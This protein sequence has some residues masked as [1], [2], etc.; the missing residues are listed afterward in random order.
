MLQSYYYQ[1]GNFSS[2]KGLTNEDLKKWKG[3]TEDPFETEEKIKDLVA[4]SSWV[5]KEVD[6]Y[7]DQQLRQA[8]QDQDFPSII[9]WRQRKVE[10]ELAGKDEAANQK[11]FAEFVAF[12]L[13]KT[14]PRSAEYEIIRETGMDPD[15]WFD[16]A[17]QGN[18]DTYNPEAG[19]N[20]KKYPPIMRQDQGGEEIRQY[21][22]TF[23]DRHF[24]SIRKTINLKI[25]GP[26]SLAEHWIFF[27]YI[28][29]G[30][31]KDHGTRHIP[32]LYLD[33]KDWLDPAAD[34]FHLRDWVR[35]GTG[36]DQNNPSWDGY[37]RWLGSPGHTAQ[38]PT[39]GWNPFINPAA[40]PAPQPGIGTPPAPPP[41]PGWNGGGG[42]GG[43]GSGGG[44]GGGGGPPVTAVTGAHPPPTP[45]PLGATGTPA[46]PATP[47]TDATSTA[48]TRRMPVTGDVADADPVAPIPI[49]EIQKNSV[50]QHLATTG[51]TELA[52]MMLNGSLDDTTVASVITIVNSMNRNKRE[53]DALSLRIPHA[54]PALQKAHTG[55]INVLKYI[56]TQSMQ[57]LNDIRNANTRISEADLFEE[58]NLDE[59][60]REHVEP[61]PEAP[62]PFISPAQT[63][64][65]TTTT[66][67]TV[68]ESVKS[69][70]RTRTPTARYAPI[71][72]PEEAGK[73][74]SKKHQRVGFSTIEWNPETLRLEKEMRTNAI[75]EKIR[76]KPFKEVS[77]EIAQSGSSEEIKILKDY[78]KVKLF[79]EG[80]QTSEEDTFRLSELFLGSDEEINEEHKKMIDNWIL[81]DNEI[82]A[83]ERMRNTAPLLFAK[84]SKADKAVAATAITPIPGD[85]DSQ[86]I[87]RNFL[88]YRNVGDKEKAEVRNR[89]KEVFAD[90]YAEQVQLNKEIGDG[91]GNPKG[92]FENFANL[93]VEGSET[94]KNLLEIFNEALVASELRKDQARIQRELTE[95]Q[96]KATE[97]E[98][99]R[100]QG[101]KT[102]DELMLQLATDFADFKAATT[103]KDDKGR[104]QTKI[105]S[106]DHVNRIISDAYYATLRFS[107]Q[108]MNIEDISKFA[109]EI[110]GAEI[111]PRTEGHLLLSGVYLASIAQIAKQTGAK[112]EDVVKPVLE[113]TV[114]GIN[115]E[116]ELVKQYISQVSKVAECNVA[117][118]K[119]INASSDAFIGFIQ[120][121]TSDPLA[122]TAAS[123]MVINSINLMRREILSAQGNSDVMAAANLYSDIMT[124]LQAGNDY[125]Y[126]V[127]ETLQT[128]I[129][130]IVNH[131]ST[132]T[133][134]EKTAHPRTGYI[135]HLN[136]LIEIVSS[137][138]R[139]IGSINDTSDYRHNL[140]INRALS[141]LTAINNSAKEI[142]D[143]EKTILDYHILSENV[144][145]LELE[146]MI[147]TSIVS[148]PFENKETALQERTDQTKALETLQADYSSVLGILG[149][150]FNDIGAELVV[151][152]QDVENSIKNYFAETPEILVDASKVDI[153]RRPHYFKQFINQDKTGYLYNTL[154][155][156]GE[157][158]HA[159]N[160][161]T[162]G[163]IS[164]SSTTIQNLIAELGRRVANLNTSLHHSR[165][166]VRR[167]LDTQT[168][169]PFIPP[170]Q[171][172]TVDTKPAAGL[173]KS[174]FTSLISNFS[175]Y[176][177]ESR[178]IEIDLNEIYDDVVQVDPGSESR[179]AAVVIAQ[180]DTRL[181]IPKITGTENPV[182]FVLGYSPETGSGEE[183]SEEEEVTDSDEE[184]DINYGHTQTGAEL[185]ELFKGKYRSPKNSTDVHHLVKLLEDD[186][187]FLPVNSESVSDGTPEDFLAAPFYKIRDEQYVSEKSEGLEVENS[188]IR[189]NDEVF[190]QLDTEL[191]RSMK[192]YNDLI[193][194]LESNPL[195]MM[196]YAEMVKK[197]TE[198]A[199]YLTSL[200]NK[201]Y[202]SLLY[203]IKRAFVIEKDIKSISN[204]LA[205]S[206]VAN[207]DDLAMF[208][209]ADVTTIGIIYEFVNELSDKSHPLADGTRAVLASFIRTIKESSTPDK[210]GGTLIASSI[211]NLMRLMSN[212]ILN[213][214][215]LLRRIKNKDSIQTLKTGLVKSSEEIA[216]VISKRIE[217]EATVIQKASDDLA[218]EL[219][220]IA[221]TANSENEAEALVNLK[222]AQVLSVTK[223]P[224]EVPEIIVESAL[225]KLQTAESTT[226]S[227]VSKP[228]I[229]YVQPEQVKKLVYTYTD[230]TGS[231]SGSQKLSSSFNPSPLVNP[232][233]RKWKPSVVISKEAVEAA[234]NARTMAISDILSPK[235]VD[236]SEEDIEE[237]KTQLESRNNRLKLFAGIAASTGPASTAITDIYKADSG[238]KSLKDLIVRSNLN[239]PAGHT[240]FGITIKDIKDYVLLVSQTYNYENLKA[241]DWKPNHR[242]KFFRLMEATDYEEFGANGVPWPYLLDVLGDNESRKP[243]YIFWLR[244]HTRTRRALAEKMKQVNH[245]IEKL[246]RNKNSLKELDEEERK[247]YEELR[248]QEIKLQMIDPVNKNK[249]L[250][251]T[252]NKL[253]KGVSHTVRETVNQDFQAWLRQR[254]YFSKGRRNV[255]NWINNFGVGVK[256]WGITVNW[257]NWYMAFGENPHDHTGEMS[258]F[259]IMTCIRLGISA[260][261]Y[262]KM[263]PK[264]KIEQQISA[265]QSIELRDRN[266]TMILNSNAKPKSYTKEEIDKRAERQAKH[267][268]EKGY[269]K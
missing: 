223:I 228:V 124:Q 194:K 100:R 195:K 95:A 241:K 220:E 231:S 239:I 20:I 226:T 166:D 267:F 208:C 2:V 261:Y 191:G 263:T 14:D 158:V 167:V 201:T 98:N 81:G 177:P 29:K 148:M 156:Y 140:V 23:L 168:E 150:S 13:G 254:G 212:D 153:S 257:R 152:I 110:A 192:T 89:F 38:P 78:H 147:I 229:K 127:I 92:E 58:M 155:L 247:Q 240:G 133:N 224:E 216:D 253:T 252:M 230:G 109:G 234:K 31:I 122:G 209:N 214:E 135:K 97:A 28:V 62:A 173:I 106:V 41:G 15:M 215:E 202:G 204:E 103:T 265:K 179:P 65:T 50:A 149:Q 18:Y 213:N 198:T 3:A 131:Y 1:Q 243:N 39:R 185:L 93:F 34:Q 175:T 176:E 193:L 142:I 188:Q 104:F 73:E 90:V 17:R 255:A 48:P 248:R 171:T 210:W 238:Q 164:Q 83:Y 10:R 47:P 206:G 269:K 143:S 141:M 56:N 80:V 236:A 25:Q 128:A 139:A 116:S 45:P 151:R 51:N 61:S 235:N 233:A 82:Q 145:L 32:E 43:G 227:T 54:P 67:T 59:P 55:R 181:V 184:M 196:I 178:V 86:R 170:S 225:T 221:T 74:A 266:K 132:I 11:F 130:L 37:R 251:A 256:L 262:K 222:I 117:L 161:Y 69:R 134:L 154:W 182:T 120:K 40:P 157:L 246:L 27:K 52:G 232:N 244:G 33:Y 258:E 4:P 72:S 125:G 159:Y 118:S 5:S 96:K 211:K 102:T 245:S 26:R 91:K 63:T 189:I 57:Q 250:E 197:N 160:S 24:R 119:I 88:N 8:Y 165:E 9:A 121:I 219:K 217:E 105:L 107:Q 53:I 163:G 99:R 101:I 44:G 94:R 77:K 242:E 75:L 203:A 64:T 259:D 12:L 126:S 113:K 22:K 180:S 249:I 264:E 16:L 174:A 6:M 114:T 137:S 21:I 199:D 79:A 19:W 144:R 162:T 108:P 172:T 36:F 30:H 218:E 190:Y 183:E 68:S 169:A 66:T 260:E 186:E 87:Y 60:P 268:G 146:R 123:G 136:R 70:P 42:G 207:S 237:W 187:R 115:L 112:A 111:D 7:I 76:S 129:P 205:N 71:P 85:E 46:A 49:S 200:Y 84:M 35:P 138:I